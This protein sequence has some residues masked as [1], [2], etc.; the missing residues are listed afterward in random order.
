VL[1]LDVSP[2]MIRL[3]RERSRQYGNIEF[4]VA[5][6]VLWE[7]P[8]QHFDC[9]VS[10]ATLHHLPLEA[11]LAKMKDALRVNGVLLIL[12]LYQESLAGAFTTLAALPVDLVLKYLNTGRFTEPPEVRA[13]WAEHGKHDT[14]LTLSQF[15]HRCQVLLPG[16]KIGKHLLWRYSLMWKKTATS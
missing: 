1:A 6:A 12:D 4:L 3:A 7:F 13:A 15:R 16:V 9:I 14:Y 11:M 5:D 10:I 2:Q 8:P